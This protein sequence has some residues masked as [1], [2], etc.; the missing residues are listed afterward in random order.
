ML[1]RKGPMDLQ[2]SMN[3]PEARKLTEIRP[4]NYQGTRGKGRVPTVPDP[5]IL[6]IH[7]ENRIGSEKDHRE[8]WKKQ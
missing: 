8:S 4:E 1:V 7:N 6:V 5:M 3:W 2:V